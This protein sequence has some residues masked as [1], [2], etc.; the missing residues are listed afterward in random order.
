VIR[1]RRDPFFKSRPSRPLRVATL[2]CA[3][4][5]VAIPYIGPIAHLFGFRPI[6]F[7]FRPLPLSFL[8][9]LAG[10]TVTYF[11]LGQLGV[12]RFFKPQGGRA[13]ARAIGRQERRIMRRASRWNLWS[14]HTPPVPSASRRSDEHTAR[15]S[16]SGRL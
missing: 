1:T 9:V 16:P 3:G 13:L 11:A 14:R 8:A 4:V 10:M 5:G 6:L 12:A 2:V 15:L 7:G